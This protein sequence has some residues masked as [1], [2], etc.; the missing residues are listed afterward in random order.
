MRC[1]PDQ[2]VKRAAFDQMRNIWSNARAFG[3]MRAHLAK[4]ATF[5][6]LCCAFAQMRCA[7]GHPYQQWPNA[8]AIG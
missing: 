4:C 1:V 6:Q 2:L 5:G 3:Q 8:N 7:F